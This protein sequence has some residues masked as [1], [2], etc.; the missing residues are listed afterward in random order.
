MISDFTASDW[1]AIL[2]AVGVLVAGIATAA[3]KIIAAIREVELKTE[4]VKD[5]VDGRASRMEAKIEALQKEL[6]GKAVLIAKQDQ[7]AAVLAQQAVPSPAKET[8][9]LDAP[10]REPVEVK[11]VNPEHDPAHVKPVESAELPVPKK[12]AKVRP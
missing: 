2:S 7:A 4:A 1:I 5:Q 3:I 11:V 10:P 9:I 12:G 6:E 8:T